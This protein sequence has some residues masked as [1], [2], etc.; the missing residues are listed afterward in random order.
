M[1]EDDLRRAFDRKAVPRNLESR[2]LSRVRQ[3]Q[4]SAH[5]ASIVRRRSLK[6]LAAAAAIALMAI[7]GARYY[8]HQRNV[9]EARRIESEIRL[10]M[11]LTNEALATVQVTLRETA[12]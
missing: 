10:A 1:I 11:Q 2:V 8:E 5:A 9:A 4:R 3:E 12:R 6:R 7:G